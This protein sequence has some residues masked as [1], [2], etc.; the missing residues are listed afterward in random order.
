MSLF[1]SWRLSFF[2][3]N[4]RVGPS[5]FLVNPNTKEPRWLYLCGRSGLQAGQVRIVRDLLILQHENESVSKILESWKVKPRK[6][7]E[8]HPANSLVLKGKDSKPRVFAHGHPPGTK[9]DE[10]PDALAPSSVLCL[11]FDVI[12][13]QQILDFSLII[14]QYSC[15]FILGVTD[16]ELIFQKYCHWSLSLLTYINHLPKTP[17]PV[18]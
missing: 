12:S 17:A 5:W 10:D 3:V 16:K 2:F 6:T 18:G 11:L 7:S 8:N 15:W 4:L 1:T 9:Q 14:L 13:V